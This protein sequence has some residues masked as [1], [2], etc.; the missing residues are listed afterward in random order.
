MRYKYLVYNISV[1][2]FLCFGFFLLMIFSTSEPKPPKIDAKIFQTADL[3]FLKNELSSKNIVILGESLHDD[4]STFSSKTEIVKYLYDTLGFNTLLFEAGLYD[5]KNFNPEYPEKSLWHF[6]AESIQMNDLWKF[7]KDSEIE[8]GG[9]DCQFSGDI[10]DS[11]RYDRL[12]SLFDSYGIKYPVTKKIF[13]QVLQYMSN[14]KLNLFYDSDTLQLL[15]NEMNVATSLLPDCY[16]KMYVNGIK[17]T[18][19]YQSLYGV[20]DN[21]RIHWRDSIMYENTI[22]HL[23]KGKKTI[24][25]CANMHASK[26]YY[27]NY[28]MKHT[29]YKNLGYRLHDKYGDSL[30]VILY[31]NWGRKLPKN[32]RPYYLPKTNSFEYALHLY[33]H[34]QNIYVTDLNRMPSMMISRVFEAEFEF[35]ISDMADAVFFVDTMENVQYNEETN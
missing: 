12:L 10:P 7:I 16:E 24:I 28:L 9:I 30:Y 29:N 19:Q 4:G 21:R 34:G 23:K 27:R 25:W 26:E 22:W 15:L 1:L 8:I 32:K 20:G 13:R 6:W 3:S 35:C 33:S 17:N 2:C 5:M 18:I 31:D 14:D 11:T